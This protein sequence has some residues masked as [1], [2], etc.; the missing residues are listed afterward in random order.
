MPRYV[1]YLTPCQFFQS[2]YRL[3]DAFPRVWQITR[4]FRD[5]LRGRPRHWI[6]QMWFQRFEF[7]VSGNYF[8]S[9]VYFY[10][11]EKQKELVRVLACT[12]YSSFCFYQR[13]AD[14]KYIVGHTRSTASAVSTWWSCSARGVSFGVFRLCSTVPVRNASKSL[15]RGADVDQTPLATNV[16]VI[17]LLTAGHFFLFEGNATRALSH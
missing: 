3:R 12:R 13:L 5:L 6:F 4:S 14:M 10:F 15:V 2:R 17:A 16:G 1:P 11:C 9:Q 7:A 8:V